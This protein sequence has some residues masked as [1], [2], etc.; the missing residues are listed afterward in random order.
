MIWFGLGTKQCRVV[1]QKTVV[2]IPFFWPVLYRLCCS[3]GEAQLNPCVDDDE[4]R[5][6]RNVALDT[7]AMFFFGGQR[8][9]R[10]IS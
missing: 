4:G 3:F 2:F 8:C 5:L 1:F 9:N 6:G 7:A 10:K